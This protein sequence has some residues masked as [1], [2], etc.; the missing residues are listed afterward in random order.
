MF[1]G[2]VYF[3]TL[4]NAE[5]TDSPPNSE[6]MHLR[7]SLS[8]TNESQVPGA[9]AGQLPQFRRSFVPGLVWIHRITQSLGPISY[10]LGNPVTKA[11][12]T[13][14]ASPGWVVEAVRV[15]RLPGAYSTA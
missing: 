7:Y 8:L 13:S 10:C 3:N 11:A 1:A 12:R 5:S 15:L 14:A 2:A 6:Y 9:R 4:S